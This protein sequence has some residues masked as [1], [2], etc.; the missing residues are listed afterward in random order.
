MTK[1]EA[2]LSHKAKDGPLA[3]Q[4]QDALAPVLPGIDIFLSEEIDKS[5]DFREEIWKTLARAKFFVLLYTDPSEDWSW[6]F[7]EAG[8]FHSARPEKGPRQRQIYCLHT[9]DSLR[10]SPLANLQTIKAEAA[11]IKLWIEDMRKL[12]KRRAPP[13]SRVDEAASQIESAFK[14]RSILVE[15]PLK[16]NIWITPRWPNQRRPNFNKANLPRIPLENAVVTIDSV[17]AT[18]LGFDKPPEEMQ[19]M[20]FLKKLDCDSGDWDSGQPYWLERFF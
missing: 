8:A 6:C 5:K 12:L 9:K 19:L 17:S 3:K 20:P 13:K 10:P 15:Q 11:D 14:A 7:F 16:P 1:I 4:I 18:K 2:F